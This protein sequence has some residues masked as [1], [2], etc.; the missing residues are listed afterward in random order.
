M[1]PVQKLYRYLVNKTWYGEYKWRHGI[2]ARSISMQKK[3]PLSTDSELQRKILADLK[4]YG[5]STFQINNLEGGSGLFEDIIAEEKK[6]HHEQAKR[7]EE[8]RLQLNSS[9]PAQTGGKGY[10]VDIFPGNKNPDAQLPSTRLALHPQ[11]LGVVNSYMGL[12]TKL[13]YLSFWLNLHKK[14]QKEMASQFW[15]R[16]HEDRKLV[17]LFLYLEN[18]DAES[19]P[20]CY[21]PGMHKGKL[22]NVD[23]KDSTGKTSGTIRANDSDMGRVIPP[24]KWFTGIAPKGTI[25]MADTKSYHKGGLAR[26]RDRH[27]LTAAY[28]SENYHEIHLKNGITGVD[29]NAHPAIRFASQP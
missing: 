24:E 14:D 5:I 22:R 19:G 10:L 1:N 13:R 3:H 7:I 29:P 25:I 23:P 12:Y 9:D 17:K 11:I 15:H 2:N 28:Y 26:T 4:R 20:F 18:V 16:D 8:Q 21:I 6:Y 27:L